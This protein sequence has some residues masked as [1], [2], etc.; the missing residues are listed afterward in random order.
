M[1]K[2]VQ[3]Y[4]ALVA[5]RLKILSFAYGVSEQVQKQSTTEIEKVRWQFKV[6]QTANVLRNNLGIASY[7]QLA[8]YMD[9]L[10]LI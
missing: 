2:T 1:A 4:W 6:Q 9:K 3:C 10:K 7:Y 8:P 5:S